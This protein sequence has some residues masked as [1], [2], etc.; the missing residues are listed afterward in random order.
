MSVKELV[1]QLTAHPDFKGAIAYQQS[2]EPT[3]WVWRSQN[4]AAGLVFLELASH[5]LCKT[6]PAAAPLVAPPNIVVEL[7]DATS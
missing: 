3:D 7:D 4:C 6:P 1:E 2:T 5:I